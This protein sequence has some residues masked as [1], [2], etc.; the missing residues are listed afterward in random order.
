MRQASLRPSARRRKPRQ[1]PLARVTERSGDTLGGRLQV[2]L[3]PGAPAQSSP[4][5]PSC[6]SARLLFIAF[7][8]RRAPLVPDDSQQLPTRLSSP[9]RGGVCSLISRKNL[10]RALKLPVG[11]SLWPGRWTG[12]TGQA[13]A[14][15][16]AWM[17]DKP[18]SIPPSA[19]GVG[20]C[21]PKERGC[22]FSTRRGQHKQQRFHHP[23]LLR[24]AWEIT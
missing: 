16:P 15:C 22:I 1:G 14:S 19:R 12:L 11:R 24:A 2:R 6:V 13:G 17:L 10:R 3:D 8:P 9:S 18:A 7:I 20:R 4:S 21:S 23:Y 5:L